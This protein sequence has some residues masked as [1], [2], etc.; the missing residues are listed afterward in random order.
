MGSDRGGVRWA[1]GRGVGDAEP[2]P[3]CTGRHARWMAV[4]FAAGAT[5]CLIG[6]FPGYLALVGPVADFLTFFVGSLLFTA[7]GALRCCWPRLN[8]ETPVERRGG[9]RPSSSPGRCSSTSRPSGPCRRRCRTRTTTGCRQPAIDLL[10]CVLFGVAVI[11][12]Y[13][14]PPTGSVLD[15]AA[16][17]WNTADGAACFLVCAVAG[18]VGGDVAPP[19]PSAPVPHGHGRPAPSRKRTA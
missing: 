9:R 17:N 2:R 8:G 16:A 14:V 7:G 18:L 10:G 13:V 15:L 11:A 3:R 5:C 6:P 12:G 4:A 1:S 19:R